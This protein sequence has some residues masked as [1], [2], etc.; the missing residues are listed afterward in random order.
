MKKEDAARE[1]DSEH[2]IKSVESLQRWP[3]RK[4][5]AATLSV[6]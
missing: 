1:Q 2:G 3:E 4:M 5:K 6:S